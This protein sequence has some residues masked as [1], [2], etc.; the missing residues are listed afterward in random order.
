MEILVPVL[1]GYAIGV[2]ISVPLIYAINKFIW[3]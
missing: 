2:I 3:R 1:I